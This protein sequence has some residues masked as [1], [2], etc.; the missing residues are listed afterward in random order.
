MTKPTN[1]MKLKYSEYSCLQVC[2][3][4]DVKVI[5]KIYTESKLICKYVSNKHRTKTEKQN[6]VT[7]RRRS[8][9]HRAKV[10]K[11]RRKNCLRRM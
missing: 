11:T 6:N 7:I 5:D 10:T 1:M 9:Q 2:K 4:D 3:V 8:T